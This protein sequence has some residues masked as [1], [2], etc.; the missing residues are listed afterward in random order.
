[1]VV[2]NGKRG[3]IGIIQDETTL[4]L[5]DTTILDLHHHNYEYWIGLSG[6]YNSGV[7]CGN[8]TSMAPFVATSGNDDYG[9]WLCI[10]GTGDTPVSAGNTLFD[11]HRILFVDSSIRSE[12]FR[13]QTVAAADTSAAD[14]EE[15]AERVVESM[16]IPATN[17]VDGVP[18]ELLSIRRTA[19]VPLWLRIWVDGQD[20]KTYSFFLG[21]HEYTV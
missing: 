20:A 21:I 11:P 1:M 12:I 9:A 8:R 10:L 5:T 7:D 13:V 16:I 15:A 4:T 18:L 14:V 2:I 6:S 3:D 17:Q 19:G